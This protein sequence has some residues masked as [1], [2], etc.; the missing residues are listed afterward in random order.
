MT[1]VSVIKGKHQ[2]PTCRIVCVRELGH[3]SVFSYSTLCRNGQSRP[4]G[5][6]DTR[7][8]STAYVLFYNWII[9]VSYE[10]HHGNLELIEYHGTGISVSFWIQGRRIGTKNYGLHNMVSPYESR[11]KVNPACLITEVSFVCIQG[12]QNITMDSHKAKSCRH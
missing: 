9:E 3:F 6:K 7:N 10:P 1:M 5:Y 12:Y 4:D 8:F 11:S 2:R